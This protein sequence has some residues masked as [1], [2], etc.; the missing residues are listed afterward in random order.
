MQDVYVDKMEKNQGF[1]WPY[2]LQKKLLFLCM[3]IACI[4]SRIII[5][6]FYIYDAFCW[7]LSGGFAWSIYFVFIYRDR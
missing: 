7:F 1:P 2:P 3:P 6:C 5:A 4:T